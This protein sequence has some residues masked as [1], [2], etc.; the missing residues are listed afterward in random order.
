MRLLDPE[1]Y[2][3]RRRRGPFV[4]RSGLSRTRIVIRIESSYG[5]AEEMR[6]RGDFEAALPLY[7]ECADLSR[8]LGLSTEEIR[9]RMKIGL[10]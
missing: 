9:A 3:P 6:L 4:F 2:S 10:I 5:R 1:S 7:V 8:G